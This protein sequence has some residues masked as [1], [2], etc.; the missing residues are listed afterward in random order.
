MYIYTGTCIGYLRR[1]IIK[2]ALGMVKSVL[3]ILI[4]A[5]D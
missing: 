5:Y 3:V 4:Y 1:D 2:S